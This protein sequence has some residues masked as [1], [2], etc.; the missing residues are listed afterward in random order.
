MGQAR[1]Y[2]HFDNVAE[3]IGHDLN[4]YAHTAVRSDGTPDLDT[5]NWQLLSTHLR[6]VAELAKRFGKPLGLAAEAEL[7]GQLHDLGKYSKR[8]QARLHDNTIHGINHWAA[9]SAHAGE[10]L[11]QLA[12][13]FAVDGHHTGIPP[14]DGN[15][16]KQEAPSG[17]SARG[18]DK[19]AQHSA[20]PEYR[21]EFEQM[22]C[23]C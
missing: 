15:Q 20:L 12:V 22:Q 9:G 1:R 5:A 6:N 10:T 8:F 19:K 13:A 16:G 14:L 21:H 18:R 3:G 7:A 11:K 4:Y 2:K 17:L 23:Y